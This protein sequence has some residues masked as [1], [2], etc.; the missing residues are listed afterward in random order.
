MEPRVDVLKLRAF[1]IGPI[2]DRDAEAGSE[3]RSTYE[4]AVE[5][6]EYVISPACNALD[7]DAFRADHI[8]R[9]GEINEQ[10]CRHLRDSHIVIADLTGANPNVMYELGLR[11][12][13]GKLT[14]QIGEKGKL[15]FDISTIRTILFKRTEAGLI[16]AKRSLIAALAEGLE[17]GS[18]PVTATRIWLEM[19]SI[20]NG[21]ES[22]NPDVL[23]ELNGQPGFLEQLAD[24]EGGLADMT[25]T[26][27]RGSAILEEISSILNNGTQRIQDLPVTANYSAQ[28]LAAANQIAQELQDPSVRLNIVAQDFRNH[29]DRTAPGVEY[30]LQE[31][32]KNPDQ[33]AQAPDFLEAF[34][35][36]I[37]VAD[38]VA[39]NSE[40]FAKTIEQSGAATRMMKR[41]SDSI[42]NSTLSMSRTARKIESWKKLVDQIDGL[43]LEGKSSQ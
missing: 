1:V 27:I 34:I 39:S 23:D 6:F 35:S 20:E 38:T 41:V 32:I 29:V 13:T 26:T 31:A 16:S 33:L 12:T 22:H 4:D 3:A 19:P 40:T 15:P 10:I 7:F 17:Q 37:S 36:L 18:D 11:H 42:R 8:S 9:T 5:V 43:K 2:G 21:I 25:Q 24:M 28:K 14:V 30:L